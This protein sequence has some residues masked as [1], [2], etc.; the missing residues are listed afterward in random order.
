MDILHST[1]TLH[2]HP[3]HFITFD[4]ATFAERDLLWLPHHDRLANAG[5]KR[6]SEHLAGRIAAVHAL[7]NYGHQ[8]VPGIGAGGEP[9]WPAGLYGSISHAGQTAVAVVS[10]A[11]V[12]VDIESV[13]SP[14]LS[15]EIAESIVNAEENALLQRASLPFE[16]G[17]SLAF[18]A[19]ES[20]FKAFST[21]AFPGFHSAQ[22]IALNDGS[23]TLRTN[24]Q[25][26]RHHAGM[27]VDIAWISHA[28]QILTL[29]SGIPTG[30]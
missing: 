7:R 18:S 1:L 26:S 11:C 13:F 5:R 12:G 19:K 17:L 6:K 29:V 14:Q 9:L 16:Q 30:S 2:S 3:V 24:A 21:L 8:A 22:L 10:P 28:E 15:K 23:L 27:C 4:P 25:F 20:L